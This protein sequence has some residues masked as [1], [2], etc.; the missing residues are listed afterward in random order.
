MILWEQR[1]DLTDNQ[2]LRA[3]PAGSGRAPSVPGSY[4]ASLAADGVHNRVLGLQRDEIERVRA[5]HMRLAGKKMRENCVAPSV[6]T[7]YHQIMTFRNSAKRDGYMK[8]CSQ[9]E[10]ALSTRTVVT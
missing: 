10:L 9:R 2:R 7:S 6:G 5:D 3:A 4:P 8:P 1:D